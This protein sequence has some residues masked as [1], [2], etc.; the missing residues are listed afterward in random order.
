[1][2][3][4]VVLGIDPGPKLH[5]FAVLER[6]ITARRTSAWTCRQ[7][8]RKS[9]HDVVGLAKTL[10]PS[11]RPVVVAIEEPERVHPRQMTLGA[12]FS[13]GTSLIGSHQKIGD[14]RVELERLGL[15]VVLITCA[16]SRKAR[17]I[18]GEHQ[19]R[20]TLDH[21]LRFVLSWPKKSNTHMRD[22]AIVG[23]AGFDRWR[24]PALLNERTGR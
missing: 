10:V 19:D 15:P 3:T 9:T 16:S 22:A 7:A 1:M 14:M 20:Q 12:A 23:L 11:D 17:G 2:I 6:S 13:I 24:Q 21:L 18:V 5:G 8:G 4:H